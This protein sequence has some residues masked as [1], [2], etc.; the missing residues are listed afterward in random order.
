[1]TTTKVSK[2]FI[3]ISFFFARI[4]MEIKPDYE[5]KT[6][7]LFDT[8]K[9]AKAVIYRKDNYTFKD[10]EIKIA[11]GKTYIIG[12][13]I[14]YA[15]KSTST[16]VNEKKQFENYE[17]PH[18]LLAYVKFYIDIHESLLIYS[19]SRSHI[20]KDSFPARFLQ[21]IESANIEPR[22]PIKITPVTE[23]YEF[24][25][26]L[27]EIREIKKVTIQLKPSNPNSRDIWKEVD[28]KL[29]ER[30][31]TSSKEI[32]ENKIN[33]STIKFDDEM[34]AKA[35]M[36]EDGYGET[37]AEGIDMKGKHIKIISSSKEIQAKTE[38]EA[39]DVEE[40]TIYKL[41]DKILAIKE[42]KNE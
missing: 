4:S 26:R 9:N 14:K 34:K 36:S 15:L 31:I 33:G 23:K 7:Y 10:I 41:Q 6:Q 29:K 35:K 8:L 20:P 30:G 42:K 37:I 5:F 19:E 38:I 13:M 27:S 17:I 21:I 28:E 18:P 39:S 1:M 32:L 24:V 16:I 11:A 22:I 12:S 2:L 3:M 25:N 40:E